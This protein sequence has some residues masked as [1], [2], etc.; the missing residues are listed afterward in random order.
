VDKLHSEFGRS[1]AW[2]DL[3]AESSSDLQTSNSANDTRESVDPLDEAAASG[4]PD[5][6][7]GGMIGGDSSSADGTTP[8]TSSLLD[9]TISTTPPW[10]TLPSIP[11]SAL[12]VGGGIPAATFSTQL[13]PASTGEAGFVRPAAPSA[14]PTGIIG[15]ASS[16]NCSSSVPSA[17]TL[18]TLP[19][20]AS[21]EGCGTLPSTGGVFLNHY[22]TLVNP[23][24]GSYVF[25]EGTVRFDTS[26][27]RFDPNDQYLYGTIGFSLPGGGAGGQTPASLAF[28]YTCNN[29][30]TAGDVGE[31]GPAAAAPVNGGD[32]NFAGGLKYEYG[33]A[34]KL[35]DYGQVEWYVKWKQLA[36][37]VNGWIIQEVTMTNSAVSCEGKDLVP[38]DKRY[39]RY[40]EGWQVVDGKVFDVKKGDIAPGGDV[41]DYFKTV[42]YGPRTQGTQTIHGRVAFFPNYVAEFPPWSEGTGE[43]PAGD[44]PTLDPNLGGVLFEGLGA[45]FYHHRLRTKW[46]DCGPGHFATKKWTLFQ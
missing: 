17:T 4:E 22:D 31:A 23:G 27:W 12:A 7:G 42:D 35:P 32:P 10:T 44:L 19:R 37:G 11:S 38:P 15:P 30:D 43:A 25:P 16:P 3:E 34:E 18:T 21:A 33:A 39:R 1:L 2:F 29:C 26:P 5:A 28:G 9:T 14:S 45:D 46:C 36:P 8:S 13:A 24:S 41:D 40:Y 6:S 20:A